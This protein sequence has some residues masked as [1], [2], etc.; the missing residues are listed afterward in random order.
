MA[1][2]KGRAEKRR[3]AVSKEKEFKIVMDMAI[4]DVPPGYV[5]EEAGKKLLPE[6]EEPKFASYV[7]TGMHRERSPERE[8]WFPIRCASI[9][10]RAYKEGVIGTEMLRS[11]YGG[12][13]NRGRKKEHFYKA[14]GKVIRTCVQ[15]LEKKGYLKKAEPKGRKITQKGMQ[16]L[17]SAAKIAQE[18][19]KQGKYV[20]KVRMVVEDKVKREVEQALRAQDKREKDK[21]AKPEKVHQAKRAEKKAEVTE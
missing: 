7:K 9:L 12:K 1:P 21:H 10:Y 17:D 19:W 2:R 20:K 18:N 6:L 14:S 11:Y 13:R 16:L 15:Q 3:K 4:Q 8:D 5:V